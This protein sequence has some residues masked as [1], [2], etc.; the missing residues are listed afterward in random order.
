MLQLQLG[1]DESVFV[2]ISVF[3]FCLIRNCNQYDTFLEWSESLH[4]KLDAKSSSIKTLMATCAEKSGKFSTGI[5]KLLPASV[6]LA[7]S[8][9]FIFLSWNSGRMVPT[10]PAY[11]PFFTQNS[12]NGLLSYLNQEVTAISLLTA[13]AIA[14]NA[15]LVTVNYS[16]A[17]MQV[18][19]MMLRAAGPD[20]GKKFKKTLKKIVDIHCEVIEQLDTLNELVKLPLLGFVGTTYSLLLISWIIVFFEPQLVF[21][22]IICTGVSTLFVSICWINEKLIEASDELRFALYDL[23]W[24]TMSTNQRRSLLSVMIMADRPKLLSA[25]PF[26]L[27]SYE[28]LADMLNRVYSYGMIINNLVG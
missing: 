18:M 10:L 14:F 2:M 20:D 28:G 16:I 9:N 19:A 22:C 26:D 25:G 5:L 6:L 12:L 4:T 24:Y 27:I 1:F 3:W 17:L 8:L 21:L 15:I 13:F 23:E 7:G 11:V